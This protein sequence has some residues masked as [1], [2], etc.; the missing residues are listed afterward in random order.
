MK[1]EISNMFDKN[2]YKDTFSVLKAP[3][4]TLLEVMKMKNKRKSVWQFTPVRVLAT[5]LAAVMVLTLGV[6]AFNGWDYSRVFN[7][8]FGNTEEVKVPHTINP[9][10]RNMVN[11]FDNLELN[12]LGVAGDAKAFYMIV[13]FEKK[14]GYELEFHKNSLIFTGFA[15]ENEIIS[16]YHG[17]NTSY[18]KISETDNKEIWVQAVGFNR[19]IMS[20]GWASFGYGA[21]GYEVNDSPFELIGE[22]KIT[23]DV[24]IDYDFA[25]KRVFEVNEISN[26]PL[27]NGD[28]APMFIKEVEITPIGVRYVA[29]LNANI[30]SANSVQIKLNNGDIIDT[31][32]DNFTWGGRNERGGD[33]EATYVSVYF[34]LPYDLDEVY[35]V[36]IGDLEI[37][38]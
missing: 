22:E 33:V 14:N 10:V 29:E 37:I 13:E 12:V 26:M 11:T 28:F 30:D 31:I 16:P 4:N 19:F 20:K 1:M 7:G 3:D 24:L 32:V 35:S 2:L 18:W 38:L 15:T 17:C 23:F 25:A 8:I 36:I 5:S 9:E 6:G 34:D 21:H 27:N